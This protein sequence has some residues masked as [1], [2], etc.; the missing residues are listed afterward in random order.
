MSTLVH[1]R[2][3]GGQNWVKIGSK[4]VHVVVECPLCHYIFRYSSLGS[5]RT[6]DILKVS[7]CIVCLICDSDPYIFSVHTVSLH[8]SRRKNECVPCCVPHTMS[9]AGWRLVR[10]ERAVTIRGSM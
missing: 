5:N 10:G 3:G 6:K 2:G 7:T 8:S 1:S 9:T 4:L